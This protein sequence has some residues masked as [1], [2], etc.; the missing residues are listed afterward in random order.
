MY[1]RLETLD[2]DVA[3]EAARAVSTEALTGGLA[4]VGCEPL[5]YGAEKFGFVM[6]VPAM[7]RVIQNE[8]NAA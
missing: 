8:Q 3:V 2:R 4:A 5:T 7:V 1:G 6:A